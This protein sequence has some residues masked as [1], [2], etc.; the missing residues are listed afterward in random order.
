MKTAFWGKKNKKT[1]TKVFYE[2][3]RVE[4]YIN[5]QFRFSINFAWYINSIK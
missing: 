1:G 2:N 4:K 3:N 5:L